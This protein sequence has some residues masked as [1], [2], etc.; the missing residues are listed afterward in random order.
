MKKF[1]LLSLLAL[2][3]AGLTVNAQELMPEATLDYPAG[4]YASFA[5]SSVSVTYGNKPIQLIDPMVNDWEEEYRLAYVQLGEGSE[6]LPA[7]ASILYSFGDPDN[8]EDEDIWNLDIALYEIDDLWS[9]TG[10]KVI[11]TIPEGIVA[12]EEGDINPEQTLVF[13]IVQTATDYTLSPESGSTLS[14]DKT[15]VIS[16][17]DNQIER[18]QAEVRAM[19]Y[20]PVYQDITLKFGESVSINSDNQLCIDL[21]SLAPGE[22]EVVVPEGYVMISDGDSHKLSPDIWL[23][24]IIE[25]NEDS[26][27]AVVEAESSETLYTISGMRVKGTPAKGIYVSAGKKIIV[28]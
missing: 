11:V 7:S 14:S 8:P 18:L 25:E 26:G 17:S 22:Y 3:G 20:D 12:N 5:P 24:Y 28:K 15:L 27:V 1:T 10:D 2:S 19:T 6:K 23:E 16:F 13:Y 9:F 4:Y 21:S